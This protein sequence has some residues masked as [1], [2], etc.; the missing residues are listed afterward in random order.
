MTGKLKKNIFQEDTGLSTVYKIFWILS[1][2]GVKSKDTMITEV[3]KVYDN[4]M[5]K[6]KLPVKT[7]YDKRS[8]LSHIWCFPGGSEGK[9]SA[10]NAGDLG[11]IPG[12]GRPA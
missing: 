4:P 2:L 6:W 12:S 9:A 5:K 1:E 3:Y 7:Q 8:I 11:L 10:H